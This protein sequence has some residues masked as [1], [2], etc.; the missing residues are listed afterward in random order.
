MSDI[1]FDIPGFKN[2]YQISRSGHVLALEKTLKS[3]RGNGI[4]LRKQKLIKDRPDKDGYRI[5]SLSK[6]KEAFTLKIHRLLGI[7][8]I[9][10]P[11]NKPQINHKNRIKYD[12][13][14]SN[15]EWVTQSENML[16]SYRNGTR[17]SIMNGM[18]PYSKTV[19]KY[20]LNK[21]LI[22]VYLSASDAGRKNKL[23]P[24]NISKCC[25]LKKG[26]CGGF[27]WEY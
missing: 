14:L 21:N 15:L 26:T 16:H 25:R 10:N 11:E 13:N 20:D 1:W 17:K 4:V 6:N 27:I 22:D 3:S 7:V 18:N 9:D 8:F 24:T 5:I 23:I 2:I 12:N 19:Y